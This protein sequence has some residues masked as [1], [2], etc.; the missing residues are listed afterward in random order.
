MYS[1][2]RGITALTRRHTERSYYRDS[3]ATYSAPFLSVW[4]SSCV[5]YPLF[6][7]PPS[8]QSFFSFPES[9]LFLAW[10]KLIL[11]LHYYPELARVS[12][13][14]PWRTLEYELPFRS[15]VAFTSFSHW[16]SAMVFP[17][18]YA[19][20][21]WHLVW[22]LL[23]RFVNPKQAET[24]HI[25]PTACSSGDGLCVGTNDMYCFF[26]YRQERRLLKCRE[27]V[28]FKDGS[29]R[30]IRKVGRAS[31]SDGGLL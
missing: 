16:P 24:S 28:Y 6:I 20:M 5:S 14:F 10:G 2:G 12:T 21:P 31:E 25:P 8:R 26:V 13:A 9:T 30:W 18:F 3:I 17:H 23:S 22:S 27:N 29:G 11:C 1:S 19:T 15:D 7:L 4:G